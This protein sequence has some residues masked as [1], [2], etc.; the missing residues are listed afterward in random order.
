MCISILKKI[1][2]TNRMFIIMN[3]NKQENSFHVFIYSY[4]WYKV[5]RLIVTCNL[6][7][8]NRSI[9]SRTKLIFVTVTSMHFNLAM[10]IIVYRYINSRQ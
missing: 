7:I 10:K 2:V 8:V 5:N 1:V 4:P 6:S 3:S 9:L